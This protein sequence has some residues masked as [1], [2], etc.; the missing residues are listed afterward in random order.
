MPDDLIILP[1]DLIITSG[2]INPRYHHLIA[3]LQWERTIQPNLRKDKRNKL[4]S[5]SFIKIY[6]M[7]MT[8]T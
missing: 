2:E 5:T 1:D 3:G 8:T 7:R 6:H 4:I